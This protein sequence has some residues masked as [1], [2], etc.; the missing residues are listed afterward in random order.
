[1]RCWRTVA[2]ACALA[3]LLAAP[4]IASPAYYGGNCA[5]YAREVTGLEL[6]GNA[7]AWWGHAQGHYQRGQEPS[8]GA[9]LVFKPSGHMHSGH[10]AVVSRV[11]GRREILVDQANWLRGR[12]VKNM[13]VIDASPNNDWTSVKVLELSS[14]THGRE[15]PTFGFIYPTRQPQQTNDRV[16]VAS[17]SE[18]AQKVALPVHLA[19]AASA[20]PLR[21][22]PSQ[23]AHVEL[24]GYHPIAEQ[25]A[26]RDKNETLRGET[27]APKAKHE[28]DHAKTDAAKAKHEK[29][30]AANSKT[31]ASKVKREKREAHRG[32]SEASKVKRKNH[33]T[34]QTA[35]G[36]VRAKPEKHVAEHGDATKSD[37]KR[38][39]RDSRHAD[40]TDPPR[41]STPKQKATN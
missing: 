40:A 19:T 20:P 36:E 32:E 37:A 24:I 23:K 17:D 10:V 7:G 41:S 29:H 35:A 28:T 22:E 38:D 21:A 18:K 16:V 31:D 5:L 9:V 8:V 26:P 14:R 39:H 11:I 27:N 30:E 15:N 13:S 25:N 33:E 6:S 3:I 2:F 34:H 1:V 12:I 4:A